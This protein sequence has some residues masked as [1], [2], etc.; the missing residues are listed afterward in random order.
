MVVL[1]WLTLIRWKGS[2]LCFI[3]HFTITQVGI[4]FKSNFSECIMPKFSYH[5]PLSKRAISPQP[6]IWLTQ[7]MQPNESQPMSGHWRY[8]SICHNTI[9][10]LTSTENTLKSKIK[11]ELKFV[12]SSG[13]KM[14]SSKITR[15]MMTTRM[16][17]NED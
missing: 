12:E 6:T 16:K 1:F 13:L 8:I 11:D 3:P 15:E 17:R 10:H 14:T 7:A 4:L 9:R 5:P 2:K